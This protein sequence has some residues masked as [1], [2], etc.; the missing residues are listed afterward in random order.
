MAR[1]RREAG[2]LA[3]VEHDHLL[4]LRGVLP[5]HDGVVL[6]LPLAE[7]GDLAA[8]LH[9]RG[10]LRPGQVVTLAAPLAAAL[11]EVHS[12]G[13]V[14]GEVSPGNVLLDAVGRPLLADLGVAWL[15]ELGGAAPGPAPAFVAP[16]FVAPEVLAG[17]PPSAAS[18]VWSL[19][20]VARLALLGAPGVPGPSDGWDRSG[21]LAGAVR[22][23]GAVAPDLLDA[24][25]GALDHDPWCRPSA[26]ALA[27]ALLRSCSAEPLEPSEGVARRGEASGGRARHADVDPG[28]ERATG[29]AVASAPARRAA[30][31]ADQP[32]WAAVL[33]GSLSG[34]PAGGVAQTVPARSAAPVS[35]RWTSR[36]EVAARDLPGADPVGGE[37]LR[38]RAAA[39]AAGSLVLAVGLVLWYPPGQATPAAATALPGL[40]EQA[41]P[42]S[43]RAPGPSGRSSSGASPAAPSPAAPPSSPAASP[44]RAVVADLARARARAYARADPAMLDEVYAPGSAA[45]AVDAERLQELRAEGQRVEGLAHDVFAAQRLPAPGPDVVLRVTDAL[46]AHRV[47]DEDG[48]ARDLPGRGTAASLVTLRETPEGWRVLRVE[49]ADGGR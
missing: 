16:G 1:V 3:L 2:A 47:L 39:A 27:A 5:Q 26:G 29:T 38:V 8:L 11:A 33:D 31:S 24:L 44:W 20:A 22:D 12:R 13:R 9:R 46:A 43:A 45:R 18:D 37:R 14:H 30:S 28:D 36:E 10:C 7:G 40:S 23:A 35:R 15:A 32:A 19:G 41:S 6:V 4:P 25:A 48:H 49:D 21:G 34:W 17:E 42:P